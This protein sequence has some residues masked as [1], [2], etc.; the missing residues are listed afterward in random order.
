[1]TTPHPG[2]KC[3]RTKRSDGT[4]CGQAAGWGTDHPGIGACK[5]HGGSA[6]S[7]RVAAQREAAQ[8]AVRTLGL[9]LDIDP[10][11]ALLDEVRRTAGHVTWLGE[12]IAELAP[13]DLVQGVRGIRRR[14]GPDGDDVTT[15]AGPAVS[16]W[17]D[18]YQR[19]RRH[20]VAVCAAA[21]AAGVAERQVR[22]AEQQ[23]A[24]ITEGLRWLAAMITLRW[25]LDARRAGD[26]HSWVATML[27]A[28]ADGSPLPALTT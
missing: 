16:V 12:R 10:A 24:Q 13:N 28:L 7:G 8:A 2:P 21:V 11:T 3:G 26:F 18:L 5:L 19:E 27:G 4:P 20:L 6:P 1:M 9:P 23:G 14:Q 25:D 22:L 15:E 17:L